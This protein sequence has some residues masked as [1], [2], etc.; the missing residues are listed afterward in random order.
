MPIE[1]V[2]SKG[3]NHLQSSE[4]L[5]R[6]VWKLSNLNARARHRV[7]PLGC[8]AL[9]AF[10]QPIDRIVLLH[11][12]TF[13]LKEDDGATEAGPAGKWNVGQIGI[14]G[15]DIELTLGGGFENG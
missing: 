8:K 6:F 12:A 3:M 2:T 13:K 11:V 1:P 14:V 10:E 5:S 9:V 4:L 7:Q 15:Q